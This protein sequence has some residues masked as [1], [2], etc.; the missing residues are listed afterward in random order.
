[1]LNAYPVGFNYTIFQTLAPLG[2]IILF[3][4]VV[5][6]C[7]IFSFIMVVRVLY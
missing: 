3:L 7:V 1:M 2:L 4:S 5:R 6:T